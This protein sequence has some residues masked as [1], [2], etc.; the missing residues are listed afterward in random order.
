M[1][2]RDARR[3]PAQVLL[4]AVGLVLGALGILVAPAGRRPLAV[5]LVIAGLALGLGLAARL[6][7]RAE[8]PTLMGRLND[9]A[10]AA[11]LGVAAFV[12]AAA[13]RPYGSLACGLVGGLV[14]GRGLLRRP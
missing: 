6:P 7:A 10:F 14:A 5:V 4:P 1:S 8:P 2:A 3:G 9:V 11:V 13:V 12:V